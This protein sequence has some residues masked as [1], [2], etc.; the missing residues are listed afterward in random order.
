MCA[1]FSSTVSLIFYRYKYEEKIDWSRTYIVCPN[2]TSNLD[3]MSV[4]GSLHN[5]FCFMGKHELL[6]SPAAWHI[7]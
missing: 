1:S 4:S 5:T 6:E 7:F 2:H 3:I